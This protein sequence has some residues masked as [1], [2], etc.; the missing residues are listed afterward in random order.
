MLTRFLAAVISLALMRSQNCLPVESINSPYLQQGGRG[1]KLLKTNGRGA[2]KESKET[3]R[4]GK[5][6]KHGGLGQEW[7]GEYAR[8]VRDNTRNATIDLDV[9]Q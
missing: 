3:P 8:F 2:E 7:R 4:G 6:L 5:S 1:C 9:C